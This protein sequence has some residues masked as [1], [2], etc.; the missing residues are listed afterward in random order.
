[1]RT[2]LNSTI[3]SPQARLSSLSTDM[4]KSTA[5]LCKPTENRTAEDVA[6]IVQDYHLA[7]LSRQLSLVGRREVLSGKA[8]F[9]IFGDG[10]ELA[11]IALAKVFQPGDWRAGY[12]RD[13]TFMLAL[14]LMT[15]AQ[16][17]A[18]LY[19]NT[20]VN[21]EPMSGGRSMVSHFATRLLDEAG[22]W[23]P[24]LDLYNSSAD[25]SPT[26]GQMA[27]L[28][29]LAYASRLYREIPELQQFP[30]FS[31]NGNEVAF[32]TIG[33]ASCAQGLFWEALNAIGVLNAPAVISIWDDEY[34]ISVPNEYQL[35]KPNLSALLTGF[36]RT[37]TGRGFDLYQVRGWDYASLLAIYAQATQIA[38]DQHIPAIIHVTEMTQPQGHS[39]SGSHA[40]Y[41]AKERLDW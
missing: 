34:G 40:R 27:R 11:Q 36:Q 35:A 3:H 19:A 9:G 1:M 10:K 15:P 17:F 38:R 2:L 30:N 23:R 20:D 18:Q 25:V 28:V 14:G 29:G 8:K 32:G 21:A 12:Y 41:K 24:Q 16:F 26:A 13:Q 22:Q 39:T 5:A 31:H 37:K 33:N 6:E 4:A 7:C